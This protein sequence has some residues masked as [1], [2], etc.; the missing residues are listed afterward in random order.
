MAQNGEDVVSDG[1]SYPVSPG[2]NSMHSN[3]ANESED[4]SEHQ[5]ESKEHVTR[6]VSQVI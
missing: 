3:S 5:F 4:E 2:T 6:L 1:D